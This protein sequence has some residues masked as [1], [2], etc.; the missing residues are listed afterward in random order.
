MALK[1]L[2]IYK[3]A[4][5]TGNLYETVVIMSKRARQLATNEKVELDEKL[6]YFEGFEAE[7]D[8]T[9]MNEEQSRISK[10]YEVQ[11]KASESAV[12][13]MLNDR[14]YHRRPG[15]EDNLL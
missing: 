12:E 11:P 13:E 14:I 8:D 9:R 3:L 4:A 5:K 2:D 15:E 6:Q 1:T 7:I 10:E